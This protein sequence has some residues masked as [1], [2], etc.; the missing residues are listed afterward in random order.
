MHL[1][2]SIISVTTALVLN[3]SEPGN[4]SITLLVAAWDNLQPAGCGARCR[5]VA[6]DETPIP[7]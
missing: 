4:L 5:N 6:A 3:E 1:M 7:S 2:I